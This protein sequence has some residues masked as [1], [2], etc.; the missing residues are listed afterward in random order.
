M[1]MLYLD[2]GYFEGATYTWSTGDIMQ[3]TVITNSGT[4]WVRVDY[5]GCVGTDTIEVNVKPSL[6][7]DFLFSQQGNCLPLPVAFIDRSSACEVNIISWQ[8]DFGDGGFSFDQHPEHIFLENGEYTVRLTITDDWGNSFTRSKRIAVNGANPTVNLGRDT[9]IC[10]GDVLM[11]N[12]GNPEGMFNWSTGETT[13]EIYVIDD[14]DYWVQVTVGE[15]TSF[16]TI[17]VTTTMPVMP[18][19]NFTVDGTCLP[20]KVNFK[21]ATSTNCNNNIVQWRWDFG[22]GTTST[23][24]NPEHIY[25]MAD[26]FGVKL[27]VVTNTGYTISKVKK[28][29]VVNVTPTL[30]LGQDITIC[31]GQNVKLNSNVEGD[32]YKWTPAQTL[33]NATI[34]DP[35]AKPDQT[36]TYSLTV[37]KCMAELKDDIKVIVTQPVKPLIKQDG[38]SL[39]ASEASSWQWYKN[40]KKVD[41]ANRKNFTPDGVGHYSVQVTNAN[42]CEY[43]SDKHFFMPD[44][45]KIKGLTGIKVQ[46]SPN[47]SPGVVYLYLSKV[48]EKNIQ[49]TVLDRY[50]KPLFT[51]NVRSNIHVFH[52][53]T[54]A[55]GQ[56]FIELR[57]GDERVTLPVLIQ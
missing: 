18:S 8:W 56:Y 52:L 6:M 24:Q 41:R 11:L 3:T 42:G 36:T 46:C 35:V 37:E 55:K 30:E 10:F 2:A 4:V 40:G 47:P 9:T 50:G 48:P 32:S 53:T 28:V 49:A 34:P 14:G 51:T 54:V 25:T 15:C 57:M 33:N 1:Q 19:F 26:S 20:I 38:N 44:L 12:A 21:D 39:I 45:T 16:D 43:Q 27:T 17:H 23:E 29:H 5:N 22:D 13:Q 7:P 31:Q